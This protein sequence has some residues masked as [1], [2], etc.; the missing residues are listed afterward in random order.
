[1]R[2]SDRKLNFSERER[3]RAGVW[4]E[5]METIMNEENE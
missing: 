1:M 2:G 5:H 3:D 4:K